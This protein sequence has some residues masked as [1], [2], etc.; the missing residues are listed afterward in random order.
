MKQLRIGILCFFSLMIISMVK[1]N[2]KKDFSGKWKYSDLATEELFVVR[3]KKKQLEYTENGKYY[4]EFEI[5]WLSS[6]QYQAIYKGTNS[7]TP[8]YARIGEINTIT[9]LEIDGDRMKYHSK[10]RDIEE[11]GEMTRI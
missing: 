5:K 2:C 6:C 10:I 4:Y 3:T 1:D 7:P 11:V 8:A 9:I